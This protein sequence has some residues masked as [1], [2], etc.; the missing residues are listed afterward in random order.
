M[1]KY[2]RNNEG[3][4]G[5]ALLVVLFFIAS[6][7]TFLTMLAFSSSQRAYTSRRLT[8]EIKAKAMA[9]AGCEY[10][11]AVLSTDWESRYDPA[12]FSSSSSGQSQVNSASSLSGEYSSSSSEEAKYLLTVEPVG[13]LSALVTSTGTCGKAEAVSVISVQNIGGSSPDGDVLDGDAFQYA[14]LSGGQMDF[15]GC[16]AIVAPG[17]VAKFHSNSSMFLRGNTDPQIS[18][19]SSSKIRISNNVDVGGDVT[20]PELQYNSGKVDID[21]TA[22]EASVD[23]VEIP[24]IDLTPYYN[25]AKRR[26]EVYNGY[27]SSSSYTPIGG[28]MWVNGDV[29]LDA[30]AVIYGSII[31][32]GNIYIAGQASIYPTTSAFCVASRDGDI[33][34]TSTGTLNGLIYAKTGD[35]SYTANGTINGQIIVNGDINKGGNSDLLTSY[36]QSVPAPPDGATTTDYIAISAWQE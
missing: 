12:T 15:G 34:V 16:G 36:E 27:A 4:S 1:N 29:Y 11:Y 25:W 22:T 7:S 5:F 14:A 20:A 10:A 21:G 18:L 3:K 8:N 31:A 13:D 32:T 30:H 35:F 33:V 9:E 17:G 6:I 26:G 28:I 19:S 2:S 23:T 24:D